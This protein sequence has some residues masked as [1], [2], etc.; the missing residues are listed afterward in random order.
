MKARS[1][2]SALLGL[3]LAA[4]LAY[5]AWYLVRF[6]AGLFAGVGREVT[7]ATLAAAATLLV[8]ASMVSRGLHAVARRDDVLRAERAAAYEAVFRLRDAGIPDGR[9]DAEDAR[10]LLLASPAVLGALRRLRHAE[11]SGGDAKRE[12]AE[13]VAAMRR[14][15]G[16]RGP[17]VGIGEMAELL[18]G[19]AA[20]PQP[21]VA[22]RLNGHGRMNG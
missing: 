11:A 14:D 12:M 7:V 13:L 9:G 4:G 20:R 22:S 19:T 21:A 15:L 8:C 3:A 6:G 16:H 2:L 17:E 5:A 18:P 10:L 1:T